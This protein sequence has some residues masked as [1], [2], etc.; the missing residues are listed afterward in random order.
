MYVQFSPFL[1]LSLSLP[2]SLCFS[3]RYQFPCFSLFLDNHGACNKLALVQC[4]FDGPEIEVITEPRG[5]SKGSTPY[6][7]TSDSACQKLQTLAATKNPKAVI[8]LRSWWWTWYPSDAPQNW[9]LV[10]NIHRSTTGWDKNVLY[11]VMLECK[12]TQGSEDM[13]VHDDK[14]VPS[15][16]C[17]LFFIGNCRTWDTTHQQ[18]KVWYFHSWY[19]I[20]SWE[21]YVTP[22]AY[23]Q[24]M[25]EDVGS[26]QHPTMVG[27][28]LV[29]QQTDITSF[30]YF[31][32]TLISHNK[33][34]HNI[35]F[36]KWWR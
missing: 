11:S 3:R 15:P 30:N 36:W 20:Q 13:F 19:N 2:L 16:Q 22:T 7:W 35:C 12:A 9:Q 23:P 32:S 18:Q 27:P 5:N 17:V 8:H 28:I 29:H 31:V 1:S 34:L 26:K 33:H 14:A 25:L 24:L 21:F 4:I 10:S 6:F